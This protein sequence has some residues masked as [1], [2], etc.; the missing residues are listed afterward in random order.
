MTLAERLPETARILQE[1]IDAR[2]HKG[3]QIYVS[4]DA[5][6]AADAALGEASP[7]VPMTGDTLTLWL[8]AG[9]PLT[10]AAV[11]QLCEKGLL[12][13]DDAVA[14]HIPEFQQGGKARITIRHLLTHTGG[15]RDADAGWPESNWESVIQRICEAPIEVDWTPGERAGYHTSTSWFILG[16]IIERLDGR[17]FR[18]YLREEICEPLGMF[19]TWNGVP[20]ERQDDYGDRIGW[21]YHRQ[22]AELVPQSWHE[23]PR[24]AAVS[25][26]SNTRGPARELGQFYE[27]LLGAG[28]RD[29]KRILSAES[30]AELTSRQREGLF[31]ET[32]RHT[33]DFGLGFL[34]DSN[35]YGVDTVPYSFGRHCSPETFGHGGAQSSM[36]FADPDRG[37][38][39]IVV[40]N[41]MPGEGRHNRR[42]KA[43]NEAV[44]RDLDF[45]R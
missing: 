4:V 29:G 15:F 38:V 23:N 36:G 10:A 41:G 42:N 8:S 34:I 24:C 40:T 13:W 22:G 11:A 32:F 30:V 6:I 5:K 37:L 39:V 3:V 16:E 14:R 26:G 45:D 2:L 12:D 44:Y 1:G 21:I 27:M 35:R 17:G 7:G 31:D 19:D 33:V 20:L 28:S 18:A 25:P 9:K 43:V